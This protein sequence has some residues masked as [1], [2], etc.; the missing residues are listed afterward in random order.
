MKQSDKKDYKKPVL[1]EYGDLK[2]ITK[3]SWGGTDDGIPH[4]GDAS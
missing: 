3:G 1:R 2:H 4:R